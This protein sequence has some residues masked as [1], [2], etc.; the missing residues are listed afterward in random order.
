M[1]LLESM[2]CGTPV[3]CSDIPAFREIAR[4]HALFFNTESPIQ[5]QS[6]LTHV[7]HNHSVREHMGAAGMLHAARFGE[8][9]TGKALL[10]VYRDV[11]QI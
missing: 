11:L 1:P 6:L 9:A 7:A 3:L 8:V 2:A 10:R 5:F 4:D